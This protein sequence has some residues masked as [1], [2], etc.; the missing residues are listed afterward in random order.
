[1]ID[2]QISGFRYEMARLIVEEHARGDA[3]TAAQ[4]AQAKEI[5]TTYKLQNSLVEASKEASDEE[6]CR[7]S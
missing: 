2:Y 7:D 6:S 5:I 3:V 4:L 1:M